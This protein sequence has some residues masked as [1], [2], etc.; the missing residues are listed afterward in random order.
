M[1]KK[2]T[3]IRLFLSLAALMPG[4]SKLLIALA[5]L[6]ALAAGLFT[7]LVPEFMGRF[8]DACMSSGNMVY[9]LIMLA[10]CYLLNDFTAAG[11]KL[12]VENVATDFSAALKLKAAAKILRL[13]LDFLNEQRTGGLTSKLESSVSGSV[14]LVKLVFTDLVPSF[15]IM[16]F[17]IYFAFRQSMVVGSVLIV[18]LPLCAIVV[19]WQLKNQN[20][21]RAGIMK[22]N[23]NM[24]AAISEMIYGIEEIRIAD[25]V[26]EQ[27]SKISGIA[28]EIRAGDFGHHKSMVI[29]NATRNSI[30]WIFHIVL[31]AVS[32]YLAV[33][34]RIS[35]GSII[36]N[37]LLFMA[38]V[39][40]VEEIYRYFDELQESALRA[41]EMLNILTEFPQDPSYSMHS[42]HTNVSTDKIAI[43]IENL[44][45][46]SA[47]L[48][49]RN[50]ISNVS[51]NI[52]KGEFVGL[53]GPSGCGKT[54][55]LRNILMISNGL[56]LVYINGIPHNNLSR[57][58]LAL[59]IMYVPQSPFIF[60]GTL[61]ENMVF[62]AKRYVTDNELMDAAAK[63]GLCG[64]IAE[65]KNGLDSLITERGTNLSGGQRQ[66]ISIS[67][68]FINHE[69]PIIVLDE[70]TSA[71][72]NLTEAK[73][74]SQLL[75]TGRTIVSVVHR[76]NILTEADRI[77]VMGSNGTVVQQGTYN[78]LLF[79]EGVFSELAAAETVNAESNTEST[80]K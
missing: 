44:S 36:T 18:I 66:R 78:E 10:L 71:I 62:G 23:E 70:A 14:K 45:Y 50:I 17:A 43:K 67:R 41:K 7:S 55:L 47:G 63:S 29:F 30:K 21:V 48:A 32:A 40:P 61:R 49:G 27:L 20:G 80:Y 39:K 38:A 31:L 22:S 64:F 42:V 74:Y 3:V 6:P 9:P 58:N 60:K 34:H 69:K 51:A 76:L 79:A 53:V 8:V 5:A 13:D 57:A 68:A 19:I 24:Q 28:T 65:R 12:M 4:R 72:D 73:I 56:G 2:I 52:Y 35:F 16:V 1:E 25:Y 11:R 75:S 59:H 77:I 33:N 54:S 37:S 15:F 26:N 46:E